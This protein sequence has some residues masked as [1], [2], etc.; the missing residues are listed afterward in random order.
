[1]LAAGDRAPIFQSKDSEG[2]HFHSYEDHVTGWPM[3]LVCPPSR[4]GGAT[5]RAR[6]QGL[7]IADEGAWV[8]LIGGDPPAGPA[9]GAPGGNH[10]RFR[11]L[12]D[13]GGK[14]REAIAGEAGAAV[15]VTDANQR[16]TH[17]YS[18]QPQE[19]QLAAAHAEIEAAAAARSARPIATH[20]PVLVLPR[21]LSTEICARLV[22]KWRDVSTVYQ[23]DGLKSEGFEKETGDF[24]VAI[25]NDTAA[26]SQLV[27]RDR[28]LV[29][30]L[31]AI[32]PKRLGPEIEKAFQYRIKSREDYRIACYAAEAGGFLAAHRDNPTKPTAHR[33]FTVGVLL[34]AGEYEG[35]GLTFPEYGGEFYDVETGTAV[36]WSASLLHGVRPVTAGSRFLLGAHLY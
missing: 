25:G 3:V 8:I 30:A 31:D 29:T 4:D 34:N 28:D 5:E 9:T 15:V 10:P 18:G 19:T 27:L 23:G 24:K 13:R 21:F 12:P 35:G 36:V 7:E 17:I 14:L 22:A 20:P 6:R 2:R 1:M 33:R 26:V 16:I 11:H 32:V